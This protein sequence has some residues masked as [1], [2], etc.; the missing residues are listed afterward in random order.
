LNPPL[1]NGDGTF[2]GRVAAS[3]VLPFYDAELYLEQAVRSVLSQDFRDFELILIDDGSKDKSPLIAAQL[4][5]SDARVRVVTQA[6]LGLVK[7]LNLG[8]AESLGDIVFRMDADDVCH[9]DRFGKQLRY[10]YENPECV[11]V[12]SWVNLTDPEGEILF[13]SKL[14]LEHQKIDASHMLGLGGTI[15]HPAVAIRRV[16]L[17]MVGGYR[18]DVPHAEDLDL[19]L[20]L[21]EIG[22]LANIQKSLLDYRQHHQSIGHKYRSDQLKSVERAVGMANERRKLEASQSSSSQKTENAS[23]SSEAATHRKWAWWAVAGS[24]FKT[25][26]KHLLRSLILE[27]FSILNLKLIW[28]CLVKNIGRANEAR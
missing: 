8:I 25:A 13:E 19:F 5:Q 27:P 16:A 24:N 3:V 20:R 22:E 6:N 7:A 28:V 4:A 21:A 17:E 12:G 26:R 1:S 9:V 2:T 11:A 10:L 14:P 23:F 15:C 18:A